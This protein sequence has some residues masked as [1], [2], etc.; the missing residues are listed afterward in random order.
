MTAVGAL[1]G[2]LVSVLLII[3]KISPAYSL[4]A[5][6]IVGGLLGGLPLTETVKVM[7]DGVKDVTPAI[8][9][10]LTAG[11]LSGVLIKTGAATTISNAIINTLGE[12]RV[13]AALALATMLLCAVGVFI[14]VAVITV[15]PIALSIGKRLGLS[16]SVLLIAMVGGGKCGNI[17]SPNPNTI[18]AAENFGADLSSVMFY[19]IL[20]AIVGLLFTV[21]V[22]IRLIP[23]KLTIVGPGQKEVTDDKQLPSLTSSLVAPFVTII[24]LALRPLTGITIDP[25]IALPIGGI[26]GILCMKQ[27]KKILPSMEY[28]LQKMSTV[29]VLLIGTGTIAGVIKNSTLKDWILQLLEQAHFNEIMIAP[30]SGALMSAA[31]AST[32]AGATLASASFAEAILAVGISAAW[33]AAMINSSATVLDHLPHGSFF[34]A[35]GG[36]CELTFKQRLKL[37]PYETLIG[38]VLAAST[39]LL[40]LI[41]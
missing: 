23:Q 7:T 6:A 15:A 39:T 12:K 3:K 27:W 26:C 28:G 25:L 31:T 2:L 1:I 11:V 20:P 33:G 40:C 16:P 17:I 36:V 22:I 19:N 32:T 30:V 18:I 5:G 10:I 13:F 34:H 21:F 37:I 38:A 9:R 24:L 14:D 35:T 8:I 41:W 4:I 29:A